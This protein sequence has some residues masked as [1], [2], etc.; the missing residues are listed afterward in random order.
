VPETE[1][2]LLEAKKIA[3]SGILG[4]SRVYGKLLSYL[5]LCAS[6]GRS[7]KEAEIAVDVFDKGS[8][9]DSNHDSVVRVSVHNLRQ[10]FEK[11]YSENPSN[12][13]LQLSIP[14]GEYRLIFES[15]APPVE[16]GV[17]RSTPPIWVGALIGLLILNLVIMPGFQDERSASV[18]EAVAQSQIWDG[19]LNDALP[20]MVVVGDYY[21]FG[22]LDE[23]GRVQRLIRDFEINSSGDLGD[24]LVYEPDLA[25]NYFDLDLTYLPRS[26]ALGLENL[27]QII[28]ASNIPVQITSTSEFRISDMKSHNIIY[29]G[30][31]SALGMLIDFVF[32]ASS[33][34]RVGET[35]DE[36]SNLETGEHYVSGAGIPKRSEYQDYGLIS[37]F[38][39]PSGNQFLIIAGTRD[40]GVLEAAH[41]VSDSDG[42]ELLERTISNSAGGASAFEAL[43]RVAGFD[44]TNLDASLVHFS[45]LDR[46]LIWGSEGLAQ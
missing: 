44:R 25:E 19:V 32:S 10:K 14:R 23:A 35:Y 33:D 15:I 11:Y 22:E 41:L 17:N 27:L 38:P 46:N 39:G 34:L 31:I 21:I 6:E 8:A 45:S 43:Y 42:V 37:S 29:L 1:A 5:I 30:Y 40:A 24:L 3:E 28:H 13:G 12:N 9:F 7:P 20:L 16:K 36:L 2:I 4:R 26:S 18:Y